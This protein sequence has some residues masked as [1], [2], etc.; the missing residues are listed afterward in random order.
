MTPLYVVGL[1][2]NPLSP[3][4]GAAAGLNF[5]SSFSD[6]ALAVVIVVAALF[7][8][9]C[10]LE[11]KY[12]GQFTNVAPLAIPAPRAPAA[13]APPVTAAVHIRQLRAMVATL[14][15]NP[16]ARA[17]AD[18]GPRRPADGLGLHQ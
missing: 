17:R 8:D 18:T 4:I 15:R 13:S 6:A 14:P 1:E 12:S 11:N 10:L 16:S 2:K 3:G 7:T 9:V 5:Q